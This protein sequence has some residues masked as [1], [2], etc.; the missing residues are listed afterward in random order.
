M[1]IFPNGDVVLVDVENAPTV[2]VNRTRASLLETG[3]RRG[4]R[5]HYHRRVSMPAPVRTHHVAVRVFHPPTPP[6]P[7]RPRGFIRRLFGRRRRRRRRRRAVAPP[8]PPPFQ[9]QRNVQIQAN[10]QINHIFVQLQAAEAQRNAERVRLEREAHQ[11][12]QQRANNRA[13]ETATLT[14]HSVRSANQY[15]QASSV[16]RTN[17][18][19][20]E[21]ATERS[22]ARAVT[23][24]VV[25]AAESQ[26]QAQ[27]AATTAAA[28]TQREAAARTDIIR[29]SQQIT[30]I[31]VREEHD[32]SR[33][34]ASEEDAAKK[35]LAASVAAGQAALDAASRA[36]AAQRAQ[37]QRQDSAME[38]FMRKIAEMEVRLQHM[39]AEASQKQTAYDAMLARND[40]AT[41]Q[42]AKIHLDTLRQQIAALR[43]QIDDGNREAATYNRN[44]RSVEMATA[45]L[46]AAASQ[47]QAKRNAE[48]LADVKRKDAERDR[49]EAVQ[50]GNLQNTISAARTVATEAVEKVRLQFNSRIEI[51]TRAEQNAKSA[52]Q[53]SKT[54]RSA[55]VA[56]SAEA[57]AVVEKRGR[58]MASKAEIM[59]KRADE[60]AARAR[61]LMERQIQQTKQNIG[62]EQEDQQKQARRQRAEVQAIQDGLRRTQQAER[63]A[64]LDAQKAAERRM[65]VQAQEMRSKGH[66]A[67]ANN[68]QRTFET[69]LK[70]ERKIVVPAVS[71][72]SQKHEVK[73]RA[74]RAQLELNR[75][76]QVLPPGQQTVEQV[77]AAT[78]E[79]SKGF[80]AL[81]SAAY[82]LDGIK[83]VVSDRDL[84]SDWAP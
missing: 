5:R 1:Q 7:H 66:L 10:N 33:D 43:K 15:T 3:A 55:A 68:M 11:R 12:H 61:A 8:P 81:Q 53:K 84:G 79:T 82:S 73:R 16:Q 72:I 36:A 26:Q 13:A 35:A 52:E 76:A 20:A 54:E 14:Q 38:E 49:L 31:Q 37:L 71:E 25:G 65:L 62:A 4:H 45:K 57:L 2:V 32:R 28:A 69:N 19:K 50:K 34:A 51:A 30:R 80:T 63:Q 18:A 56:R 41:A 70:A 39:I 23:G 67:E 75:P 27:L 77:R 42:R 59:K 60:D 29:T 48:R 74:A 40:A 58:E 78:G 64:G 6:R 21:A 44:R 47:E 83:F 9:I 17:A 22:V 46:L 24:E